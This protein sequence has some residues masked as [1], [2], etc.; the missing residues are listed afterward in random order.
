MAKMIPKRLSEQTKSSAEKKLFY[1]FQNMEDT[2]DWTVLHSLA[3]AKHETQSQGE[4]DFVVIIPTAGVFV[5]EVKGGMISH[6]H[7]KW[8]STDRDNTQHNIKN[9]VEEANNAMH[10]IKN[11][12]KNNAPSREVEKTLFGFGVVFPDTTIHNTVS[13]FEVADEQIADYDDCLSS[14][15][16]KNYLIRLAKYWKRRMTS[17]YTL[18]S[19]SQCEDLVM[20]LRP[21]FE[22]RLLLH[23]VIRN[24]ENQLI[25]L[26]E[27]Q[28]E[29]FETIKENERCIVRGYA[30]TGK[31]IIAVNIAKEYA[32]N[33]HQ[34]GFFC[35]NKQL[36]A[37]LKQNAVIN[38]NLICDSF[39][40]YMEAVVVRSGRELC[41]GLPGT[42][43]NEYYSK[44]LP[45]LFMKA[46]LEL[47]LPQLDFLVLDE[48]QDLITSD[49]LEALNFILDGGIKKGKWCF[50]MDSEKQNLFQRDLNEKDI[51]GLLD[52]Y[53]T[54]YTKCLLKENCRN[55]VAIIEKIDAIFG[56]K[57]K[58]KIMEER[59]ENVSIIPYLKTSEQA[60]YLEELLKT[61]TTRE[62]IL[63]EQIV[64]LSPVRF[65][66]S[67]CGLVT[68]I[69]ISRDP[70]S[71]KGSVLF[72]TI[73]GFK[74]L[75]SSVVILTDIHQLSEEQQMKNLYVG[76]TRAK[77]KLY[78][79]VQEKDAKKTEVDK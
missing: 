52:R 12:V 28:Q 24:V 49:Y 42:E 32:E 71:R 2:E 59:G 15:D 57:T 25:E 4:T 70:D 77:S 64:I 6:S 23:S 20:L 76:M 18:P 38:Q 7:G 54:Y 39:T 44:I 14:Q 62:G 11:F 66:N 48:A 47:K 3:I 65:D 1:K 36:A 75:E 13:F 33:G 68:G 73:Q 22:G 69:P 46:F 60:Q 10:S 26:T 74:G 16:L 41:R 27:S 34:T 45:N 63:P 17:S 67:V 35:Y 5:L 79:L 51:F 29:T 31:T 40:E 9:P 30:G 56:L 21:N 50:F 43:R 37:Y 61:L 8:L 55:S 58:H 19:V 72:S 53:E 78:V